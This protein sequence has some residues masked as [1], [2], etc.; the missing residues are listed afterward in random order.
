M[1]RVDDARTHTHEAYRKLTHRVNRMA[2][3]KLCAVCWF[4][5]EEALVMI[6]QDDESGSSTPTPQLEEKLT[7]SK[8]GQLEGEEGAKQ[9]NNNYHSIN[10]RYRCWIVQSEY[11]Q[12]ASAVTM[13]IDRRAREKVSWPV[14]IHWLFSVLFIWLPLFLKHSLLLFFAL[15]YLVL[16]LFVWVVFTVELPFKSYK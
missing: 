2:G 8:N 16:C 10:W 1:L 15:L 12:R 13:N 5:D 9:A 11:K 3:N 4:E 14:I 6:A 7:S